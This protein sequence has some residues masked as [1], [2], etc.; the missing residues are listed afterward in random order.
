MSVNIDMK[1]EFPREGDVTKF[2]FGTRQIGP[3][4][5]T[6]VI[7]EIGINHEGDAALC[8]RMID[9]AAQSGA[10][11]I[12]LQTVDPDSNYAVGTP[13]HTLFSAAR[14]TMEEM[15]GIFR[16]AREQKVEPFTTVGDLKTLE[17]VT[18]L[19]PP[20]YKVSSGLLT[21]TP[22][23]RATAKLGKP[24]ILSSGMAIL[25]NIDAAVA[26]VLGEANQQVA[27]LQ[28]TSLYPAPAETLNLAVI[29]SLE[30]RYN[31]PCGY[32]D[33]TDAPDSAVIAAAAGA[34]L[35]E[36]HFTLDA[37]R[38]SFDHAISL[39]PDAFSGMVRRIREV[40]TW[41]GRPE[42]SPDP[43]ELE[44]I[45]V[46]RRF[47]AAARHIDI[48]EVLSPADILFLRLRPGQSGLAP[49]QF[50]VVVGRSVAR[51]LSPQQPIQS[52]DIS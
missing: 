7:A 13:S 33:H 46:T 24:I 31:C 14:L 12:K 16:Y 17:E 22:L 52:A 15:D 11:A 9:A 49:D 51:P 40:E 50:D 38:P 2:S 36:K 21:V 23:I 8:A 39:E 19:D 43:R 41:L 44:K 25:E 48:G 10:D 18:R 30:Q 5:P 26:T 3:G 37:S 29:R 34:R 4:E 47:L 28:C 35:I 1:I 6:F 20:G 27:V 45:P 42:K 32:S